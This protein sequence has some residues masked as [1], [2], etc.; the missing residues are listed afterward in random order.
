MMSETVREAFDV[1]PGCAAAR[2]AAPG[3]RRRSS[4]N[5]LCCLPALLV[6]VRRAIDREY[7]L[8]WS[9]SHVLLALAGALGGGERGLVG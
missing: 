7:V 5:A 8:R 3:R 2:R 6:L 1:A 9:W 4:S